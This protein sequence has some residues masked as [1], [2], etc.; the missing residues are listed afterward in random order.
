MDEEGFLKR[1]ALDTVVRGGV[2]ENETI[3]LTLRSENNEP[4]NVL[5]PMEMPP[6]SSVRIG[7]RSGCK[8][9]S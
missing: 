1:V 6:S 7:L 4:T 8:N 2:P 3:S 5:N 9:S